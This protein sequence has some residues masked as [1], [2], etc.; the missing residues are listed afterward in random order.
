VCDDLSHIITK[1]RNRLVPKTIRV[2]MCLQSWGLLDHSDA[3]EAESDSDD[4]DGIGNVDIR[5]DWQWEATERS[6]AMVDSQ[7]A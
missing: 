4:N 2:I 7:L 6:E 3:D 1:Q 5:K